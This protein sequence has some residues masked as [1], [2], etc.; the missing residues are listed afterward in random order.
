MRYSHFIITRFNLRNNSP[1]W[2][3]DKTGRTV[4]TDEWMDKR[5]ELFMNFCMPSVIN[6]SNKNFLWLIY[7]D[8]TTDNGIRNIISELQ[9][10]YQGFMHFF[11]ADGYMDFLKRYGKDVLSFCDQGQDHVITTRLDNDDIIHK[12]FVKKIQESYADQHFTT[13]NFMKILM[14]TPFNNN[15]LHID[16]I[17]SNHFISLIEQIS[18]KGIEGCYSK[19]D[20]EWLDTETIQITDKPYCIE[21]ISETN[22]LNS[23]T[24]FPVLKKFR[25][26]DFG[27]GDMVVKNR[28]SDPSNF[29]IW[30]MSWRKYLISKTLKKYRH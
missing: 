30:K 27:L 26:S 9:A 18:E 12:D 23:F 28:L 7:F 13:V 22:L 16:Y 3:R 14:F 2:S 4:L 20:R 6:Q 21:I 24:G 11:F 19:G 5:M 29:K 1:A 8:E 10:K 15:K 25:L 17:F